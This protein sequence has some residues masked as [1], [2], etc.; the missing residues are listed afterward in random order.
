MGNFMYQTW[1]AA[2]WLLLLMGGEGEWEKEP[3]LPSQ[4]NPTYGVC[5]WGGGGGI[6]MHSYIILQL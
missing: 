6:G 3:P 5:V 2:V 4:S 1:P